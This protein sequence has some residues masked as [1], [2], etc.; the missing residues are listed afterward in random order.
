M[1]PSEAAPWAGALATLLA[2]VAALFKEEFTRL[3]RRPKLTAR[4]SL[5]PPDCHL[6]QIVYM[7]NVPVP[8]VNSAPCYYLRIWVQNKGNLRA[9]QVQ[10]FAAQLD[11]RQ[12][13]GSYRRVAGFL[14][15]NLRWAHGQTRD[16]GPEI[17]ADGISPEMGK[18]CDVGHL[19]EPRRRRDLGH[20]LPSV[21]QDQT[22]LALDLEV[23]P[24]TLTHLVA[25]G[26]YRLTVRIAAAN[27]KPVTKVIEL[28][29]TG[30]WY[31]DE[32]TMFS[33]GFG[34]HEVV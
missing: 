14:P 34:M 25:P 30:R 22:I 18:H 26:E 8:T 6:T 5:T 9:T 19:V 24:N 1:T 21:P 31:P 17:F 12:A 7:T 32:Q 29:H 33:D 10:V 13:D 27:A 20:D 23:Q 28:N 11:R 2:V 4:V 15:M 3:W 16:S